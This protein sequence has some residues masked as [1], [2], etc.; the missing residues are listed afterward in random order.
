MDEYLSQSLS[1]DLATKCLSARIKQIVHRSKE[2]AAFFKRRSLAEEELGKS[3][4][5]AAQALQESFIREESSQQYDTCIGINLYANSVRS[6]AS[7]CMECSEF[8]HAEANHSIFFARSC[9]ELADETLEWSRELEKTRK[10]LK[11]SAT[12]SDRVLFEAET[13]RDKAKVKYDSLAEE[14]DRA[15]GV[16]YGKKSS[17]PFK[18]SR[19]SL[20]TKQI[21]EMKHRLDIAHVDW[22]TK[23][24]TAQ[25]L[26]REMVQKLRPAYVA[27]FLETITESDANIVLQLHRFGSCTANVLNRED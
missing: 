19:N 15:Q 24:D 16:D 27:R 17:F 22:R 5:R 3:V 1:S 13:S 20:T 2:L 6:F 8:Q 11:D 23:V 12:R 14:W 4:Q 25:Q 9:L 7:S 18:T 21:E 26:R 10:T